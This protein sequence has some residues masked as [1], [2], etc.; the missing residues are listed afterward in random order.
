V[1]CLRQ[2]GFGGHVLNSDRRLPSVVGVHIN[3]S[4]KKSG[5]PPSLPSSWAADSVTVSGWAGLLPSVLVPG[6]ASWLVFASPQVAA[7]AS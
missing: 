1:W 7:A 4:R 6:L 2:Y 3:L 5:A